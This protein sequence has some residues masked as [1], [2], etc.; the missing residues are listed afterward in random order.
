LCRADVRDYVSTAP[1]I[2]PQVREMALDLIDR[3][4]E[5]SDPER[6]HQASRAVVRQPYL[7]AFQYRFALRQAETA[8]RLASTRDRYRTTLGGAR[9]RIGSYAEARAVLNQPHTADAE[10]PVRLAFLAMTEHRL[11]QADPARRT[12]ARLRTVKASPQWAKDE[13]VQ[14]LGR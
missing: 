4:R 13:A 3:Y 8:C 14:A 7:N 10:D 1:A 2:R 6:Y 12:L 9:Y 5:E 11:G